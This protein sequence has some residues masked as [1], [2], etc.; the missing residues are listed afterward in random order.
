MVQV[1]IQRI[2]CQNELIN[3]GVHA[4]WLYEVGMKPVVYKPTCSVGE[5]IGGEGKQVINRPA[6]RMHIPPSANA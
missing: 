4:S 1:F 5:H 2:H 3:A 6:L